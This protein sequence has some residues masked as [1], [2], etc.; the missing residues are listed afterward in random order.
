M[1]D[2][3]TGSERMRVQEPRRR[4]V[5]HGMAIGAIDSTRCNTVE[6]ACERMGFGGGLGRVR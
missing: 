1:L 4:E 6:Q 2:D 5:G 3:F